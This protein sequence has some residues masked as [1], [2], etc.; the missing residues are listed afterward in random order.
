MNKIII[1]RP[2]LKQGKGGVGNYYNTVEKLTDRI[3]FF[4]IGKRSY[5]TNRITQLQSIFF[6]I[7]DYIRFIF[8][9]PW[10]NLVVV[11]PSMAK[12][13]LYR[14]SLYIRIAKLFRKRVVVFWRGFNHL[15]FND[16]VKQKYNRLLRNT[17]F[18]ADHTIVL[19]NNIY[20]ALQT[21]GCHTP[22]SM[23]TTILPSYLL[24]SAP[25]QFTSRKFTILFLAR[26]E[27]D[28]GIM[29][30]LD[31]Y[32]IVKQRYPFVDMLI[33]GSGGALSD[34]QKRIMEENIPDVKLLGYVSGEVKYNV[35][36]QADMYLFPSYYEGMPNSVLEAMGMGLPVVTSRVGGLPDFF[37]NEKM[38][39]MID[40]WIPK[41]YAN[42]ISS[43]IENNQLKQVSEYNRYYAKHH[44]LDYI[45]VSKLENCLISVC[46]KQVQ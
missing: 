3:D 42:A 34:V 45:V 44:F 41:K 46:E 14:D 27:K 24:L 35:Y 15:Y 31:C 4:R 7:T 40:D 8:V 43:L 37:E 5:N 21:I 36:Y 17:F 32:K 9:V 26:L 12:N 23:A 33:A 1:L 30:A 10:Y 28:K 38:G 11:N 39:Y 13:C 29:E 16:I 18:R 6:S 25:K 19:G 20:E 2:A 22:Y